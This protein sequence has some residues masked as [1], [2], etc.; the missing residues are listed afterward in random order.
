MEVQYLPAAADWRCL[1]FNQQPT[2]VKAVSRAVIKLFLRLLYNWLWI[3]AVVCDEP[4]LSFWSDPSQLSHPFISG[5]WKILNDMDPVFLQIATW[6]C[7]EMRQKPVNLSYSF[8]KFVMSVTP[9]VPVGS[10]LCP[11]SVTAAK[12]MLVWRTLPNVSVF[13]VQLFH[14][15]GENKSKSS[16][17]FDKIWQ[18]LCFLVLDKSVDFRQIPQFLI[19]WFGWRIV[20][21]LWLTWNLLQ[22]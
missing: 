2:G 14:Q 19:K 3:L 10:V 9:T 20:L 21:W 15:V 18:N 12:C 4:G 11:T 8:V 5:T 22:I 17:P 1:T 13:F 6:T 16:P 7:P